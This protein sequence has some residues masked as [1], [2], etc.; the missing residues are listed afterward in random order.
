MASSGAKSPTIDLPTRTILPYHRRTSRF[1]HTFKPVD[2]ETLGKV[3]EE[4]DR[5][6]QAKKNG[7]K[8]RRRKPER[9][10]GEIPEWAQLSI[11]RGEQEQV[12]NLTVQQSAAKYANFMGDCYYFD[13]DNIENMRDIHGTYL[14]L[15]T[16]PL[17]SSSAS[18]RSDPHVQVFKPSHDREIHVRPLIPLDC[19]YAEHDAYMRQGEPWGEAIVHCNDQ[20]FDMGLYEPRRDGATKARC[21]STHNDGE[22]QDRLE[23]ILLYQLPLHKTEVSFGYKRLGT[24]WDEYGGEKVWG[25]WFMKIFLWSTRPETGELG[26]QTIVAAKVPRNRNVSDLYILKQHIDIPRDKRRYWKHHEKPL[27]EVKKIKGKGREKTYYDED[28]ESNSEVGYHSDD[29]LRGGY[30]DYKVY[31]GRG[32]GSDDERR[33]AMAALLGE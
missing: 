10:P 1:K 11:P 29:T 6:N 19:S 15:Y 20:Q 23:Q 14:I 30:R 17:I 4:S 21:I 24:E 32:H 8:P 31:D 22:P 2:T 9:M 12:P 26:F 16:R 18:A 28:S 7:N 3:P 33:S 25:Y 5:E 27:D 13:M